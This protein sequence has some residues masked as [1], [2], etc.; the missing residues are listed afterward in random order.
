MQDDRM[1]LNWFMEFVLSTTPLEV[2][3][4][5]VN[6]DYQTG[7]ATTSTA[8]RFPP[9]TKSLVM[10]VGISC[11]SYRDAALPPDGGTLE[12]RQVMTPRS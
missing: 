10:V 9:V 6:S 5:D 7:A 8:S 4:C 12:D 1:R 11:E 3:P 2:S